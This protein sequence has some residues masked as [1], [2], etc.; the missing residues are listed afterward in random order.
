[1]NAPADFQGYIND[2]IREAW[3]DVASIYPDDILIYSDSEEEHVE[4]VKWVMQC[5]LEATWYLKQEKCELHNETVRYVGLIQ[6][7][8]ETSMDEDKVET[9][10]LESREDDK[11]WLAE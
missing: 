4:H 3:D 7:T 11:E 10:E 2:S 6:S 8:Q 9:E 5:L 1:M